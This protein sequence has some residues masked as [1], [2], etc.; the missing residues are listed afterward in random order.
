MAKV[1]L[2]L[3]QVD[4]V[5]YD[6]VIEQITSNLN[7]SKVP[8]ILITPN[9]GQ[10][11]T[12]AANDQIKEIYQTADLSLIDGWP[13]AVAAKIAGKQKVKR[14]TGSDLI[15]KLFSEIKSDIKVG[16]IGGHDEKEIGTKLNLLY[17]NLNLQ[18]VNC[19]KWSTSIYDIKRLR[20]LVQ[21]NAIS[22]V[23]LSL[24]HPKQEL[25]AQELKTYDWA[26]SRPDWILCVGASIDFIVG[27][28]KRA[29][30]VFQ[31]IGFE[32]FYRLITNPAKFY[33]RYV[34][35]VLPSLKLIVTSIRM[36]KFN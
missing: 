20:E 7:I 24:G 5:D 33:K 31:K 36:R 23:I 18:I 12:V 34:S 14:V 32:W 26:G 15:P 27:T 21:F 22:I 17:P 3:L 19:D 6:F 30:K 35:A 28:Q 25:L 11:N 16:I 29:P 8:K 1:N 10:L 4:S 13:I 9:A 2:G